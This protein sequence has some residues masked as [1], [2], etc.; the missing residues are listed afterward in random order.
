MP[1]SHSQRFWLVCPACGREYDPSPRWY[2]CDACRDIAGFPHWVEVRYDWERVDRACL[3]RAGRV[4]DYA[5]LLPVR[6]PA[7]VQTLGEGNTPLVRIDALNREIGLPNLYLKLEFVNPTGAFK[8]RLHSV[9]MAVARELGYARAV[10]TT[11]GNA[12]V[13]CAAYAAR[14]GIA[15]LIITD[16][17]SSPEQRRLMRLFGAHITVPGRPGPVQPNA[18]ALMEDLVREHAFYPCTLMGTFAGPGNPYG[19]EGYKTIAFEIA[20]QLGRVPDRMCVP[21]AGGDALYG[22]FKGFRELCSL[23]VTDRV[24]RMTAC[25]PTGANFIVQSLQRGQDHL[26][27]VEPDTIAIS[28]GDPTGSECILTAI[29]E[30][31]GNAWDAPD[32]ELLDA[33]ALLGRH[34][35]C[36]EA[37]SASPIAALRRQLRAGSLD[38]EERIVALLTGTGMKWVAQIDAAIGPPPPPLPDNA[39][40]I[41]RAMSG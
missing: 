4:W 29:R 35:I 28:I 30:S 39:A 10:L 33:L 38:P 5:S 22:P 27:T 17:G 7:Q 6:D 13:A 40:A 12:G 34:G 37:A 9:S 11:T 1:T 25:Q 8:D 41:L 19:V 15:L 32:A 20:A 21:T 24:P 2:G 26:L 31:G 16:P 14:S 23:G 3:Q 36:V 18:R